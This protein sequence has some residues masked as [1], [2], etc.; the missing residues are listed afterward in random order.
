MYLLLKENILDFSNLAIYGTSLQ[1]REYEIMKSAFNK[2]L[3]KRQIEI[4]FQNH[5]ELEEEV[6]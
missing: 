5:N 6:L 4:S 1:Q 3:S 2:G